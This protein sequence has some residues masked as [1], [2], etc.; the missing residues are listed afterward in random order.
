MLLEERKRERG[1]VAAAIRSNCEG[2][3]EK[4]K[5]KLVRALKEIPQV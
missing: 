3:G 5:E 1:C 4:G 2:V